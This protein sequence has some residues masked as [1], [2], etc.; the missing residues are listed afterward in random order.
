MKRSIVDGLVDE[1]IEFFGVMNFKLPPWALWP[2][3]R[4]KEAGAD[5]SEAKAAKLG[6]DITDFGSG[7]FFKT[8]LLLFTLRNGSGDGSLYAEKI[9]ISRDGQ[10]TPFHF[11]WRKTEDIINR[12]GASLE[13]TLA[14]ALPDGTDFDD[15]DFSLSVTESGGTSIPARN[16]SSSP[17]RA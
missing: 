4:W 5:A 2:P 6:W 10:R 13:M 3:E 16:S 1:A 15:A 11:H 12:G 8:G 9:M 17:E 7:D 14:K